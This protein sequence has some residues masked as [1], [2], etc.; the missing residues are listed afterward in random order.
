MASWNS[1]FPGQLSESPALP[2]LAASPEFDLD[3]HRVLVRAIGSADGVFATI[4][5]VPEMGTVCSGDIVYN[6]IHMWLWNSTPA[7]RQAW[8]RSL[9]SVAALEPATIIAG[10]RDPDAPDHDA[11]SVLDRSRRYIEDFD[12][13]VARSRTPV[14]VIDAMLTRY[15]GYGNRYTLFAAANSQFPP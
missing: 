3:G 12:E 6:N 1:R 4:V 14:E 7:A 9:D 5:H 8:L 10:H 15:P 2:V 11:K 13:V